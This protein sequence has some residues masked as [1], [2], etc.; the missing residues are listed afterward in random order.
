MS[1]T[2]VTNHTI[3]LKEDN[4]KFLYDEN[5]FNNFFE[6]K[7]EKDILSLSL[8]KY[9]IDNSENISMSYNKMKDIFNCNI[10]KIKNVLYILKNILII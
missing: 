4:K 3:N 8:I 5:M 2:N 1:E 9:F 7:V 6:N 10:Y